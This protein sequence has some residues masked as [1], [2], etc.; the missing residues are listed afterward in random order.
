VNVFLGLGLP[1]TIGAIYWEYVVGKPNEAWMNRPVSLTAPET[2]EVF[3]ETYPG[4]GFMVPAGELGFSV[5]VYSALAVVAVILFIIRRF[6]YGGELGGPKIHN[7]VSSCIFASLWIAYI[8][9]SAVGKEAV[10]GA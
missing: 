4:G 7:Y 5:A 6:A 3:L 10:L 1:W 8:G 9:L 2:Y